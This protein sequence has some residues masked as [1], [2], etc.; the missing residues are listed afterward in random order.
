MN[1]HINH[2]LILV[3]YVGQRDLINHAV[4]NMYGNRL[5]Q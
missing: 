1:R 4:R 5:T 2:S 3:T